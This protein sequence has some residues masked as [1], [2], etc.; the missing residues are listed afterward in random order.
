MSGAYWPSVISS[1]H[2]PAEDLR[3]LRSAYDGKRC[4]LTLSVNSEIIPHASP[5]QEHLVSV[6]LLFCMT[7]SFIAILSDWSH[8]Y[9]WTHSTLY[10]SYVLFKHYTM[11]VPTD[12]RLTDIT[13]SSL[14]AFSVHI[15]RSF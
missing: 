11:F 6:Q 8:G 3:E 7:M 12:L 4:I 1:R 15:A 2:I 14:F 5:S 9:T 13:D 10:A